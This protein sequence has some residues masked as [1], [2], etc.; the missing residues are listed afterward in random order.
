MGS[1]SEADIA[2]YRVRSGRVEKLGA[3]PT[4][5][6]SSAALLTAGPAISISTHN[7]SR[8]VLDMSLRMDI[9]GRAFN[10]P[11]HRQINVTITDVSPALVARAVRAAPGGP[12]ALADPDAPAAPPQGD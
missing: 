12:V 6:W 5:H 1:S 7:A 3:V 4:C 11:A 2:R 10:R 8:V 9:K